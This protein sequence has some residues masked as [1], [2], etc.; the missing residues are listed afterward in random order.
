MT[1]HTPT[2]QDIVFDHLRTVEQNAQARAALDVLAH[3]DTVRRAMT[4][5]DVRDHARSIWT[6]FT[7]AVPNARP[8]VKMLVFARVVPFL[9]HDAAIELAHDVWAAERME[10]ELP[11][12]T[13]MGWYPAVEMLIVGYRNGG[14]HVAIGRQGVCGC[15]A[16]AGGAL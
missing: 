4:V 15:I 10:V 9:T 11:D 12:G 5:E 3:L 8:F 16:P 13:E 6:G 2:Q 14:A 7:S 1:D